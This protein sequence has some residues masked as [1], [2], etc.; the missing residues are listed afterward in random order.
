MA[1][2]HQAPPQHPNALR[3]SA[4][5]LDLIKRFHLFSATPTRRPGKM[6]EIGYGHVL[7]PGDQDL[8]WVTE[9]QATELLREDL[10]C[11]EIYLNASLRVPVR[12]HEFDALASLVFDVGM[13]VFERSELR[14]RVNAGDR[15]GAFVELQH[16]GWQQRG[17]PESSCPRRNAEATLYLRGK[18]PS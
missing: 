1:I 18:V 9:R 7:R 5:G 6:L 13:R 11:V 2:D 16:W 4:L 12:A 3:V 8:T 15:S 10:R 17:E 14:A